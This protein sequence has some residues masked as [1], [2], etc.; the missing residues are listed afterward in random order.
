MRC[1]LPQLPQN[2][3]LDSMGEPQVW[4]YIVSSELSEM[5]LASWTG[6]LSSKQAGWKPASRMQSCPTILLTRAALSSRAGRDS[7]ANPQTKAKDAFIHSFP[8]CSGGGCD[9]AETS[10]VFDRAVGIQLQVGNIGGRVGKVRR[11]GEVQSL[12]TELS[13]EAFGDAEVAEEREI[14]VH[15]AGTA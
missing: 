10:E 1:A 9:Y 14:Q 13:F 3:A 8:A 5:I 2:P 15:Q 6:L 12:G 7:K 4:Q 11:V